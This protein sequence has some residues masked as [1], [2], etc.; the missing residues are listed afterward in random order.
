MFLCVEIPATG[1]QSHVKAAST[2]MS[3]W[4]KPIKNKTAEE[5]GIKIRIPNCKHKVWFYSRLNQQTWVKE[6]DEKPSDVDAVSETSRSSRQEMR[7]WGGEEEVQ[8]AAGAEVPLLILLLSSNLISCGSQCRGKV[9]MA[10]VHHP[11][12][13]ADT[14]R[15]SSSS[16]SP[17]RLCCS[18]L[19]QV[20]QRWTI[21]LACQGNTRG[22][23]HMAGGGAAPLSCIYTRAIGMWFCPLTMSH[24]G[25]RRRIR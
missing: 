16:S 1:S 24:F 13:Q 17:V 25:W 14:C 10:A 22:D 20:A 11:L 18:S 23:G 15:P 2:V 21:V 5:Q 6:S 4:L 7:W 12:S 8:G 3:H 9:A 19:T